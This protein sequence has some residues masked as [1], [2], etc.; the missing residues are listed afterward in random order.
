MASMIRKWTMKS[1]EPASVMLL[2][3]GCMMRGRED[4]GK[5]GLKLFSVLF[6]FCPNTPAIAQK[7]FPECP[8]IFCL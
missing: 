1:K 3:I 8:L 4:A 7:S 6:L 5:E 2:S